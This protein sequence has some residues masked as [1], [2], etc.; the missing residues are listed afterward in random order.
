ML[1]D[2]GIKFK[3]QS[4]ILSR[5]HSNNLTNALLLYKPLNPMF[6]PFFIFFQEHWKS[7]I[8]QVEVFSLEEVL[9][10]GVLHFGHFGVCYW[11]FAQLYQ[12]EGFFKTISYHNRILPFLLHQQLKPIN[13]SNRWY[14]KHN[15]R[16]VD[17]HI[18][19]EPIRRCYLVVYLLILSV[20]TIKCV[21][22]QHF[23]FA[24]IHT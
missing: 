8:Y 23:V 6:P 2:S 22:H 17:K 9:D 10:V 4:W 16:I 5:Y 20:E 1:K 11:G 21:F 18:P 15:L 24:F 7:F 14:F 19:I 3:I 12:V 13:N